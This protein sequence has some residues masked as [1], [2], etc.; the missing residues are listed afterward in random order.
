MLKNIK[1]EAKIWKNGFKGCKNTCLVFV[2]NCPDA[3]LF[4]ELH[5]Y[6]K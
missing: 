1:I 3:Y 6:V 2:Q 5:I 4:D